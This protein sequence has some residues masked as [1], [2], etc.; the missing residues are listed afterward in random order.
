[1]LGMTDKTSW[2]LRAVGNPSPIEVAMMLLSLLSVIIVLVMTFGRLDTETYRLLFFIDT[3]ICMI[4]MVNFFAGLLR[5]RNKLFYLRHH[6]IDFIASIPAIEALRIARVFQ[7]LRVIRLIRMSRSFLIP[8]I[9]QRKQA[10]LA[11]LLV[12]MV[13]IL[14]F[15]SIII[16]I[17]ESGTEGANIQTA[18]QAIWWALVTISTVGYGDFYPVS[19]AGHIVGGIVIV[20]GV[21]FFGVISGYM[22]SVFVAPDESERQERQ[23]AHKAEIKSE[24]ELALARMEETQRQMEQNQAQMLAKIAELKQALEAQKN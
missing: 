2:S 6:W 7:I 5:S 20:S 21:S 3:T 10:T 22:A 13:T 23:D 15:A 17:V 18:E 24:L 11:S 4:F 1:M 9:K 8:L 14:T 12:A 16:L 19:T